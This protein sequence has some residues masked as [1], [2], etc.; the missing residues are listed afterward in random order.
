MCRLFGLSAAPHRVHARFWL[1]EAP[2]SLEE[3]SRKNPDGTGLGYFAPDGTPVLDKQPL[4]AF[5]DA[6]FVREA[7]HISATTFISHVRWATTGEVAA[8]NT[9]PFAMGGR[10]MA[11]N[12]AIGDLPALER[13]LGDEMGLVQGKTDSERVFAL[14][15]RETERNDGDVWSGHHLGCELDR[16]QRPGLRAERAGGHAHRPVGA[17]L[18]RDASPGRARAG[19]RRPARHPPAAPRSDTLRVHS[20]DLITRPCVVVASEH[21]DESSDWRAT[22]ARA[23]CCTSPPT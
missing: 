6:A 1:L 5:E 3:Q 2:D 19:C 16:R 17:A 18:S 14:I 22:R 12:G 7:R 21:L 8:V 9:H 23:S 11:H 20:A 13:E 15:T 4:A 10:I